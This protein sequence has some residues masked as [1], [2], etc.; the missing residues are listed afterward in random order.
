MEPGR[1]KAKAMHR[2][3]RAEHFLRGSP[4]G[5]ARQEG[6]GADLDLLDAALGDLDTVGVV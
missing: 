5:V 2:N 1:R 6:W 4:W 3:V